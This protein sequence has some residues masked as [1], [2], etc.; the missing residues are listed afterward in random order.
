MIAVSIAG[1]GTMKRMPNT[2]FVITDFSRTN[3]GEKNRLRINT[4]TGSTKQTSKV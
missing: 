2:P 1:N 3:Y 4:D